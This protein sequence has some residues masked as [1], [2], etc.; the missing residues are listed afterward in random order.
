MLN[1]K[2]QITEVLFSLLVFIIL[3][4]MFFGEWLANEGE[5]Y[6]VQHSATGL[7]AFLMANMN[8]WV[9][10]GLIIGVVTTL[11]IGGNK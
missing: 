1:N 5:K 8:L 10:A 3:W 6:I 4:A 9:F 7:E 11:F 2:G